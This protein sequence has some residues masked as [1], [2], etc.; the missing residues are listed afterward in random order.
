MILDMLLGLSPI[1]VVIVGG[2][3]LM[4]AEAFSRSNDIFIKDV[5]GSN[6]LG[7]NLRGVDN[8]KTSVTKRTLDE[9][10]GEARK[11][12]S[13]DLALGSAVT[14]F[15]GSVF[16]L[17]IWMYGPERLEALR[18]LAPYFVMDRYTL[19][20]CF[21]VCAGAGLAALLAGGYLPEHKLDRG[22]FY[23]LLIFSTVGA[24]MLSGASDMLS[25][26]LALE[27][28]SL[29]VYCM[30][31]FRRGSPRSTEA[32][33]KY[34]LLGSFAAAVLVYGAALLYG[35]TGHTDFA[36]I[37]QGIVALSAPGAVGGG[38]LGLAI[39][40]IILVLGG[41][42]F[43]VSAVP[44]H[45]WTPDAYEGA[46]TPATGFMAVVVKSAAFAILLRVLLVAFQ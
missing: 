28:M 11:S 46:P 26:F 13:S 19:F 36:G 41:L 9:D 5:P 32:A 39:V 6:Q 1:L 31:G 12:A 21:I 18:T 33:V 14:L 7:S 8:K 23:P 27:T 16:A 43:K 37:K 30:T 29:G 10:E 45:M 42:A 22:E 44:F 17:A 15:A 40:G 20:F 4:L 38:K 3:L 35:A 2:S 24:M 25:L 34:F